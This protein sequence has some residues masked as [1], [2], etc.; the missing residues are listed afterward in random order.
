MVQVKYIAQSYKLITGGTKTYWG[1]ID[2]K[3]Q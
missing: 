1:M 3:K 2:I